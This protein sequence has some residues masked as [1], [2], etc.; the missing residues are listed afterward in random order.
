VA[1]VLAGQPTEISMR[2]ETAEFAVVG[3][4]EHGQLWTI[5]FDTSWKRGDWLRPITGWKSKPA[6]ESAWRKTMGR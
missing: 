6:E 1:E 4:D 3:P 5:L 2:L